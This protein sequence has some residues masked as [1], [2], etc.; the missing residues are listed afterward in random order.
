MTPE[1]H[2]LGLIAPTIDADSA[3]WWDALDEKR[4][5]LP[6]CKACGRYWFPPTPGCPHCGA[7]QH[8]LVEASGRGSLYSWVVVQR[9]LHPA[10]IND[11]PYTIALVDLE[12]GPRVF[13]RLFGVASSTGLAAEMPLRA[14]V[15]EVQDRSLL[16]FERV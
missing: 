9:A 10:F 2:Q 12:E 1:L 14:V 3:P 11:V 7:T 16:G 13:G 8:E 4:L 15:Y 5:L 6:R